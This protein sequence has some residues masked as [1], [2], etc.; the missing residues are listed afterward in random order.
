MRVGSYVK[1]LNTHRTDVKG[2]LLRRN[3]H[4]YVRVP[5]WTADGM[6]TDFW[7]LM[8]EDIEKCTKAD[9]LAAARNR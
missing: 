1:V 5:N 9:V 3:G 7:V 8:R 6:S 2:Q 4:L